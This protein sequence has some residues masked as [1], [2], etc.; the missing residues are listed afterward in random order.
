MQANRP[1]PGGAT[2]NVS[3]V[4][5]LDL[6]GAYCA[7]K[8]LF[9]KSAALYLARAGLGVRVNS[10]H[11]AWVRTP[12]AERLI[13]TAADPDAKRRSMEAMQPLGRMAEPEEVAYG[14]LYLASGEAKFVTGAERVIDGGLTGQ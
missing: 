12:L 10:V 3:S 6:A 5:G 1:A 9:T 7:S 11:P 14:V 4:V 13:E 2:V 8:G